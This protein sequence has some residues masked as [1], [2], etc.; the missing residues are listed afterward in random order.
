[1]K[2]SVA[3]RL[4]RVS[5]LPTIWSNTLAGTVMAGGEPWRFS[6]LLAAVG[7]SLLYVAGMYLNDAFDRD[8]DARERPDRP[9]PAGLVAADTVFAIGFGLMLAGLGF[10]LWAGAA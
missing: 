3:L 7:I 6:T 8:V 9:I 1:M 2:L 10:I 4:G 5:N